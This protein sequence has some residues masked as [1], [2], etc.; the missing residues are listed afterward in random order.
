MDKG[1]ITALRCRQTL[2]GD[3]F[4]SHDVRF[5]KTVKIQERFQIQ[6][7]LEV[8]NILNISNLTGFSTT[9]G[10]SFGQPT[11]RVGQ[12]FGTGGPRAFQFGGR[13]SF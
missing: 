13:F 2:I 7:F 5:T 10:P 4:W 11:A 9:I 3:D 8:F 6:G 1:T 12:A